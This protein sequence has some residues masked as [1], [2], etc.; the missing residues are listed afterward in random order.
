MSEDEGAMCQTTEWVN[1]IEHPWVVSS[2]AMAPVL[3]PRI[4]SPYV[5]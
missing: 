3:L 5:V 4:Q 2:K 1:E